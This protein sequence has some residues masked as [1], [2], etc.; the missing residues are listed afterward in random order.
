MRCGAGALTSRNRCSRDRGDATEDD[1]SLAPLTLPRPSTARLRSAPDAASISPMATVDRQP[2]RSRGTGTSD[3]AVARL[4]QE[5]IFRRTWQYAGHT[6]ELA[7]PGSFVTTRAGRRAGRPRP[8][9]RRRRSARSSTSAA[10]AA[11]SS[12]RAPA[13][14]ETLQCPYHAWTY[15]LDGSL[16]TAPRADTEPGF[17][18]DG[19]GLVPVAVDTWG[20]FVFVNPD[21][22]CGAA[23]RA[24]RRP[25][26]ARRRGRRRRR[27][28]RLPPAGRGGVRRELEGLRRELPRVLPLRRRPSELLEGDR[29]RARRVHA[30]GASDVLEPVRPAEERRRRGLRRRRRGRPRPVP[31]ALPRHRRS[32]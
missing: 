15:D 9:P 23:R 10:I 27:R 7:E 2:T 16:R 22:A 12:A 25:A 28:A 24:P 1:W 11:T 17:D 29:R 31:P 6:G 18:R 20:P 14:R 32:T 5:R 13:R 4:E 30:R 21:P 3:P 8:R 26:A 19:L